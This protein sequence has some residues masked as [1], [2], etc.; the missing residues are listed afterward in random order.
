MSIS[1]CLFSC[2]CP[3]Q[4]IAFIYLHSGPA[5]CRHTEIGTCFRPSGWCCIKAAKNGKDANGKR[6]PWIIMLYQSR[7]I[8]KWCQ[9]KSV[10]GGHDAAWILRAQACWAS[11]III[12]PTL[13]F[14]HPGVAEVFR[15]F[16]LYRSYAI[17]LFRSV[18]SWRV[19]D[20]KSR[21]S[22]SVKSE[23]NLDFW[24]KTAHSRGSDFI[25]RPDFSSQIAPSPLRKTKYL[26]SQSLIFFNLWNN[27]MAQL[28]EIHDL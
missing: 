15:K 22:R 24:R 17:R 19:Y 14:A 16:A 8:W 9:R 28:P 25:L 10:S 11:E 7:S 1:G 2:A 21:H 26:M 18:L 27:L 5:P 13:V 20:I 4:Y 3:P 12:M 23:W 6:G